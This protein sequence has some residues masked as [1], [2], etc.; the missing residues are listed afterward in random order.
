MAALFDQPPFVGSTKVISKALRVHGEE[1]AVS[2]GNSRPRSGQQAGSWVDVKTPHQETRKVVV[3]SLI[4]VIGAAVE[5]P[6]SW[7][8]HDGIAKALPSAIENAISENVERVL[9]DPAFKVSQAMFQQLHFQSGIDDLALANSKDHSAIAALT[10]TVR[11][12]ASPVDAIHNT[13]VVQALSD[14]ALG[15]H[16]RLDQHRR[17]VTS[18]LQR[19]LQ[20]EDP[21]G[22]SSAGSRRS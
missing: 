2:E 22:T 17:S 18:G 13:Q 21:A 6:L 16:A 10:A 8:I 9:S 3:P 4:K 5:C 15:G 19:T 11:K 1:G 14:P 7:S 20:G 12:I